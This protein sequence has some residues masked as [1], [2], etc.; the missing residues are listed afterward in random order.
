MG[1]QSGSSGQATVDGVG[2]SWS[3]SGRFQIGRYGDGS[4]S[5]TDSG[6]VSFGR[7]ELGVY[8]GSTGQVTVSGAGSTLTNTILEV[9]IQ[10]ESVLSVNSGGQVQSMNGYLLEHG[11]ANIEGPGSAWINNALYVDGI[12]SVTNAGYISCLSGY[13]SGGPEEA[14]VVELKGAGTLWSNRG[15]LTVGDRGAGTLTIAD[16]ASLIANAS[17]GRLDIGTYGGSG[18]LFVTSGGTLS[19]GSMRLASHANSSGQATIDG[20][21]SSMTISGSLSVGVAGDATLSILNDATV[22]VAGLTSVASSSDV[23]GE[24]RF[25]NGTLI[26]HGLLASSEELTGQGAIYTNGL[27][28]DFNLQFDSS[29][30]MKKSF[31]LQTLPGQDITI[32][33][34]VDGSAILGVGNRGMATMSIAD[35][36]Q[37]ASNSGSLG[38]HQKATGIATVDGVGST[39]TTGNLTVGTFGSGDLSITNGGEIVSGT[40]RIGYRAGATGTVR[41]DGAESTWIDRSDLFVG[42]DGHGELAVGNGAKISSDSTY[43][44]NSTGS[45]GRVSIV[46]AASTW[47]NEGFLYVGNSGTGTLIIS[48]GGSLESNSISGIGYESGS[49]GEVVVEG[50]GS[51]WDNLSTL[52]VG[53]FGNGTL[54]IADGG[55]VRNFSGNIGYSTDA[56]NSVSIAGHDSTWTNLGNLY[57]GHW[58]TGFLSISDGAL[59]TVNHET[60]VA[61]EEGASGEIHFDGGTLSTGGLIASIEKLTGVGTIETHGLVSDVDLAFDATH[62]IVQ[63]LTLDHSPGNSITINLD[64]NGSGALGAGHSGTGMLSISD[65]IQISS[66]TGYLGYHEGAIGE[67]CVDGVGSTWSISKDLYIGKYGDGDW[68]C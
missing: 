65:G 14:G 8:A 40:T 4:L 68:P 7:V 43:I 54:T 10:G 21:T 35:G 46:G 12:L 33:L 61:F 6:S 34:E 24:I 31:L 45:V 44:G 63:T 39:W 2:T 29:H 62:G 42:L 53:G 27:V 59:V 28:S 15:W 20:A 50:A 17:S 55:Y 51:T 57:V 25:A 49:T 36:V 58:G 9:G 3:G 41:V 5:I 67:A 18:S 38:Y 48:D 47:L 13:I 11:Q 23:Q 37:V 26:T 16:D 52:Y 56:A 30:G 19:S 32:D 64:I 66:T 1:Y 22:N 60:F